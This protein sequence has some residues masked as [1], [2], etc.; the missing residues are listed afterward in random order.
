MGDDDPFADFTENDR[1]IVRPTPGGRR[2]QS[3]SV[4]SDPVSTDETDF[5][6]H[7]NWFIPKGEDNALLTHAFSL[8]TL[9]TQ[10]RNTAYHHDID[11]LHNHVVA[12]IRRFESSAIREGIA[13]DQVRAAR[14]ALCSLIDETVLNTPWGSNSNWSH[15]SLLISFHK[16]AWGGEKVFQIINQLAREPE[17]KRD[18]LELLYYCLAMGFEGKYRIQ[19]QG[20]AQLEKLR[21]NLYLLLQRQRGN[22]ETQLSPRW[23]GFQDKRIKL[24]RYVP[25][26]V[27]AAVSGLLLMLVFL[28]FLF[29]VNR[30]SNPVLKAIY[31]IGKETPP[32][33]AS[34]V[35]VGLIAER[36]NLEELQGF[37]AAEVVQ[38]LLEV[39]ESQ[40]GTVVRIRG[41]FASGKDRVKKDFYPLLGRV[42]QALE[43][44]SGRIII[45]G[46]TDS[47]PIFTARFPSNWALSQARAEAVSKVIKVHGRLENR[48]VSEG[49]ADNEPVAANDTPA[50]RA[51]NRRLD[52]IVK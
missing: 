36:S 4:Q 30:D 16:E 26:W 49:R 45:A 10:L 46:N 42:A 52:I 37:L 51:L 1:T 34:P 19:E 24:I 47:I 41:L 23:E 17:A 48:V 3:Q 31:S 35:P 14:Y 12:E 5:S 11:G 6:K 13:Q 32:Q 25:L 33:L 28:S 40:E 21:E 50:N 8:L 44:V 15:K 29:V 18:L 9:V 43:T 39:L 22:I 2:Q 20:Q 27:V 38:G 7:E